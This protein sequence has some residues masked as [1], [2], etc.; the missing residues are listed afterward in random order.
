MQNLTKRNFNK[1]GIIPRHAVAE[2]V[3]N[4]L[5]NYTSLSNYMYKGFWDL[6][7]NFD[8]GIYNK[9]EKETIKVITPRGE[10]YISLNDI[11]MRFVD[12]YKVTFG[13]ATSFSS[14]NQKTKIKLLSSLRVLKPNE[15][16]NDSYMGIFGIKSEE[17]AN[18]F[19]SYLETKFVRFLVLQ[20]LFGIGLTPD[21][22]QFVPIQDFTE[23]WTDEK[24]YTKYNLT[25]AEIKFI[26][27][28]IAD[29]SDEKATRKIS[30]TPQDIQAN[31]INQQLKSQDTP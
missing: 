9:T 25:Q 26:E 5:G 30:Y 28:I 11:N 6:P 2:T 15:V 10:N 19:K 23:P 1:K 22:F 16:C 20:T 24:L 21:R 8:N 14:T 29:Y 12:S 3:I 18:N 4:K 17:Y 31:F 13:R 27:S 7:T